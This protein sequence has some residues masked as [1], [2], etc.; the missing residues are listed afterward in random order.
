MEKKFSDRLGITVETVNVQIDSVNEPLKNS[1]WNYIH[2][3]Y[4]DNRYDYW[5]VLAKWTAQ[6]FRKTPVDSLPIYD[7]ECKRWIKEYYYSLEWYDIYN[8]VEF[9]CRNYSKMIG[10]SNRTNEIQKIFNTI[11]ERELSGFRFISGELAPI[12][13]IAESEEITNAIALT[14]LNH[15]EG[16]RSH[17]Q[18]ALSLLAK[19]PYPDYRN[20]IK[21]SISAVESVAK[22]LGKD[23][24]QGLASAL[25]ELS[26][27]TNLHGA[28]KAG[29]IKLYGYTSDEDG[30]RHA[31]LDET[32][33]GFD[34][35]KYMVVSCSA[36][37][38]YLIAKA[39][40]AK[41]L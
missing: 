41:L 34:D 17:I 14:S 19:K 32:N 18:T 38:N 11:F 40:I 23:N 13:N 5:I 25:D 28:L 10:S 12:S 24:S 37:V 35:A 21:E 31:I 26:K 9:I 16:A 22:V 3:L 1:I 15:L 20:S 33:V 29:F 8:F 4:E 6:F 36:F 27:K 2:A 30:I 39:E 7:Y